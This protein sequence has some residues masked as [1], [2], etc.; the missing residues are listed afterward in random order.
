MYRVS[1]EWSAKS[2]EVIRPN[3]G[4]FER[5][6]FIRIDQVVSRYGRYCGRLRKLEIAE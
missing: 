4:Y 2:Q 5:E 3:L 1:H 6:I